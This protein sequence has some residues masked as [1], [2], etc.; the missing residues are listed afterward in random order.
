[1]VCLAALVAFVPYQL[2]K[3]N[4]SRQAFLLN[5]AIAQSEVLR[6]QAQQQAVKSIAAEEA[7]MVE[8]VRVADEAK[9]AAAKAAEKARQDAAAKA[10]AEAARKA[11]AAK[12]VAGSG[13]KD[14]TYKLLYKINNGSQVFVY[15]SDSASNRGSYTGYVTY[16]LEIYLKDGQLNIAIKNS[17]IIMFFPK[18][19]YVTVC[20]GADKVIYYYKP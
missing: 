16:D 12:A 18:S 7:R 9:A 5:E 2:N 8:V 13:S 1:M 4:E 3:Q 10:A 20:N 15:Y 17:S 19:F 11:A 14:P 6:L